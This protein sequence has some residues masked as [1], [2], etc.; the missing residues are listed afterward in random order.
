MRVRH[1]TIPVFIPEEACPNRCVFCNQHRIAGAERAPSVAEVVANVDE[2]LLTIPTGND[3]EIGFFGGNFTGIP[4]EEQMAY[5]AVVQPYIASGRVVGIRISTRP[6]YISR[7]ILLMLKQYHVS[8]IELGA[9]SLDE[10]VLKLAGRG[11]K[12]AQVHEASQMIRENGFVLGLQMMIGLPG[13]TAEKS[14]YTA[15][16]IIRLGAECTRI[17]PTLVIKETELEQLYLEGKYQPLSQE[18]AI[19]RVADIVPLFIEAGVKILRIGLHPSEGL[20]N[21]TSLVA[22]PFHVAFGEMVFSEVWRRLISI[23]VFENG[24]RNILTLTVAVGMRNASIG[25]KAIN[26]TMLLES[27][28]KVVFDESTELKGFEYHAYTA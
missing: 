24:K 17:Y 25:H 9:Q 23:M 13:D 21:K 12:A 10:Q 15:R 22:G 3:V 19:S 6:D 11:H 18:E 14:I 2:H 5:L 20:L 8:T 28:R 4:V 26:K 16:E 27:F 1:F 7:D